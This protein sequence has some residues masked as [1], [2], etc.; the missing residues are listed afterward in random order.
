[1]AAIANPILNLDMFGSLRFRLYLRYESDSSNVYA[2]SEIQPKRDFQGVFWSN[3]CPFD[4][5]VVR[6]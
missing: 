2:I 1:M 5:T 4:Y 6:N 3:C